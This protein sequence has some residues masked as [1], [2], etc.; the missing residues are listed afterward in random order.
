VL[1]GLT[2][3]QAQAVRHGPGPLLI[4]AGPTELDE[5]RAFAV[6]L[7]ALA[8]TLT[9]LVPLIG[10]PVAVQRRL[11]YALAPD[12]ECNIQCYPDL[13]TLRPD[14][15]GGG[16]VAAIVDYKVK[17]TLHSQSKADGDPQASLYLDGRWLADDPAH[18][19]SFA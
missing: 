8:L 16:P 14:E 19:F 3:E 10:R 5:P 18:E 15:N 4:V 6:G 9:E 12:L 11:E 1:A 17:G 2:P 7:E 13:E